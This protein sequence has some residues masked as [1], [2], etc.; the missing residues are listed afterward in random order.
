MYKYLYIFLI[1]LLFSCEKSSTDNNGIK[2]FDIVGNQVSSDGD[3]L[4]VSSSES[5]IG[6][7]QNILFYDIT[8]G[9]NPKLKGTFSS[10]FSRKTRIFGNYAYVL[11]E[12]MAAP[13]RSDDI[14]DSFGVTILDISDLSNPTQVGLIKTKGWAKEILV[15]GNYA[16]IADEKQGLVIYNIID[17]TAPDSITTFYKQFDIFNG[18][19]IVDVEKKGNQLFIADFFHGVR[20]LDISNIANP[21]ETTQYIIPEYANNCGNIAL[22]GDKVLMQDFWDYKVDI[23]EFNDNNELDSVGT[24]SDLYDQAPTEMIVEGNTLFMTIWWQHAFEIDLTNVANPVFVNDWE[25]NAHQS[26][27]AVSSTHV[28]VLND[29]GMAIIKR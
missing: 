26:S 13:N 18:S 27:I 5:L 17:K 9:D 12:G 10:P 24:I 28:Y 19:Y 8:D 15:E 20:V 7:A 4:V 14:Y 6:N 3:R 1:V 22:V 29:D 21:V 23:L 16:Y 25:M 2:V 11:D